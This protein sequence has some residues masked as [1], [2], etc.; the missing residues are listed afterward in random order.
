MRTTLN[1]DSDVLETAKS[2]A[3]DR[4]VSIG[5]VVS[6]IFRKG[7][8]LNYSHTTEGTL[9]VFVVSESASPI[10]SDDVILDEER[11]S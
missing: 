8:Q 4:G 3:R 10:A 9:P 11:D 7:I 6:E 2:I 5:R 1:L